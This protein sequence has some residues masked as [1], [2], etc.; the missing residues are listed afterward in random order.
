MAVLD[1]QNRG[2]NSA[3]GLTREFGFDSHTLP[4]SLYLVSKNWW[5]RRAAKG[6]NRDFCPVLVL[7]QQA[8]RAVTG[9]LNFDMR[10]A[11]SDTRVA[12]LLVCLLYTIL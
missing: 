11:A 10:R 3:Y 1:V 4:P 5:I 7:I 6:S 8:A 9:F 12:I 2:Q